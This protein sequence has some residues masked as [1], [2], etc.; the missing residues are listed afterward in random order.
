MIKAIVACS[1]EGIIAI[2][3]AMPWNVP[4]DLKRFKR[5]TSNS[6]V[7]MG[8]R[9]WE[10]LNEKSLPNRIN[11]IV[12][13]TIELDSIVNT[14]ATCYTT[15]DYAIDE[16]QLI[17]PDRDIWIIGGASIYS[18]TLPICD[19]LYLTIINKEQVCYHKGERTILQ[20]YPYV[21]NNLF[22]EVSSVTSDYATYKKLIRRATDKKSK[23]RSL[24]S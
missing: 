21:V 6:V 17:H 15:I 2:D 23:A 8:R 7:I 5:L 14:G 1:P 13:K 18:Q 12:S 24:Y 19:E 9:T 10:S 3:G 16:A 20:D 11:Y 22:K 4:E